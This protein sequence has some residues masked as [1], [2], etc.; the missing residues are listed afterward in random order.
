MKPSAC[1][2]TL[3]I[4]LTVSLS[5]LSVANATWSICL[6]DTETRE[7]AM[8]TVTC[9]QGLDLM[10][11]VP[12]IAVERGAGA[13]QALGDAHG[14]RRPI[15]FNGFLDQDDPADILVSLEGVPGHSDRQYG[16]ADTRGRTLTFSGVDTND[17]KGGVTGR[18]GTLVYAIQGNILVGECVVLAI[19][20]AI[21]STQGDIPEKLLAGMVAARDAG[22]DGRCSCLPND[23]M[24]CGC[25]PET[26]E[27]S[28]H[29][30]GL[31]VAR[32]GDPESIICNDIGCAAGDYYIRERFHRLYEDDPDPVDLMEVWF[33]FRR[34]HLIGEPDAVHSLSSFAPAAVP[35]DGMTVT[36]LTITWLDWADN[37]ITVPI[38]S[39]VI[40]HAPNSAGIS[41]IGTPVDNGDGTFTVPMTAGTC[42]GLDRFRITVDYGDKPVTMMPDPKL[43][44]GTKSGDTNCDDLVNLADFSE[45]VE[46]LAGPDTTFAPLDCSEPTFYLLDL[47][48]DRDVDLND[49]RL[50]MQASE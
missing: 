40:E 19:E 5:S 42:V 18:I 41:T 7:V 24:S 30:G 14:S 13:V 25:P 29:I 27:K 28:G 16:M 20:D 9:L 45:F 35:S 44:V 23:P 37:P 2:V 31:A 26:F 39:F 1:R 32:V 8:G 47:D 4:A 15:I 12:V 49:V 50:F 3:L 10:A 17:W 43:P 38:N 6:A 21:R 34:N 11:R 46:C 36:T 33:A 22:G 48:D